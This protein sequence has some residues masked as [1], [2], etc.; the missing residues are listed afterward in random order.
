MFD[1]PL[2]SRMSAFSSHVLDDGRSLLNAAILN[3]LMVLE[4]I[5]MAGC[6][7]EVTPP[8]VSRG[9]LHVK[10]LPNLRQNYLRGFGRSM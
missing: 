7:G 5:A 4:T 10:D 3:A 1:L 9:I 6:S 2:L 8:A